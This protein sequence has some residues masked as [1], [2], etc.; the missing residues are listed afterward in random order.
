M[1]GHGAPPELL[2]EHVSVDGELVVA[3]SRIDGGT[4]CMAIVS[5]A[6]SAWPRGKALLFTRQ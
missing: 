2:T 3:E 6:T 1:H 4:L 5:E